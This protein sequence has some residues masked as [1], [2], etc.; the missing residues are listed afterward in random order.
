MSPSMA[1]NWIKVTKT[2]LELLL[3]PSPLPTGLSEAVTTG[4]QTVALAHPLQTSP[5]P[6]KGQRESTYIMVELSLRFFLHLLIMCLCVHGHMDVHVPLQ[7]CGGQRT[8]CRPQLSQLPPHEFWPLNSGHQDW[9][10]GPLLMEPF[11]RP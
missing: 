8:T 6:R 7:T 2:G 3:H 9:Q 10:Q 5:L 11:H 1:S 4:T